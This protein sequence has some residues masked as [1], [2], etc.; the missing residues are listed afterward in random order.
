MVSISLLNQKFMKHYIIL[1]ASILVLNTIVAFKTK[2]NKVSMEIGLIGLS[3]INV[4]L[5]V[6]YFYWFYPVTK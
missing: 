2:K 6:I 4:V 1:Q 5:L 3:I